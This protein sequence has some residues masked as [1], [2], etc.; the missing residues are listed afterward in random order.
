MHILSEFTRNSLFRISCLLPYLLFSLSQATETTQLFTLK[1]DSIPAEVPIAL[2]LP[3]NNE[4]YSTP[5]YDSICSFYQENGIVPIFIGV[6]WKKV[7]FSNFEKTAKSIADSVTSH[8]TGHPVYLFG[9]SFGAVIALFT[10]RYLSS[11]QTLLCSLSP[12]FTEDLQNQI[13][14]LRFITHHFFSFKKIK[15]NWSPF[16]DTCLVFL[17]GTKDHFVFNNAI[18]NHRKTSFTCSRTYMVKNGRHSIAG[19]EYLAAIKK[20]IMKANQQ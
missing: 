19:N 15:L 1:H 11:D 12:V 20:E 9:F 7:G 17:Y 2:I 4:T 16:T 18:I 6:K 14:F 10:T 5:G 13:C 8:F 3:G